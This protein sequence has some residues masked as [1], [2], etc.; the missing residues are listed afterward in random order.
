MVAYSFHA[1]F[2][3]PIC[4][5]EK[6]HTIRKAR[7]GRS[8]H[9][10]AGEEIQ[11]YTGP[12]MRPRLF[13]R[14]TCESVQ[15]VELD[16]ETPRVEWIVREPLVDAR[17]IIT[18]GVS[19]VA[20]GA[21]EALDLFAKSDGFESWDQMRAF[22]QLNHDLGPGRWRWSGS[23]ICWKDFKGVGDE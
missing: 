18:Q 8:R 14:S 9:A 16:F 7:A 20:E 13:G 23:M 5:L 10:R 15:R 3:G 1:Q 4:R 2:I 6:T 17:G 19:V 12:R 22:W 11:H 21:Q